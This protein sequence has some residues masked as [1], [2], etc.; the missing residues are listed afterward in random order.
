MADSLPT[1]DTLLSLLNAERVEVVSLIARRL[2]REK[3]LNKTITANLQ[4]ALTRH[5]QQWQAYQ[6]LSD[7][8]STQVPD[9][10]Q[11]LASVAGVVSDLVWIAAVQNTSPEVVI[12]MLNSRQREQVLFQTQVLKAL[13]V[14]E[15][16]DNEVLKAV[17]A[18]EQSELVELYDLAQPVLKTHPL[19]V[20]TLQKLTR[21]ISGLWQ[22][23][24]STTVTLTQLPQLI[25]AGDW[26]TLLK[27]ANDATAEEALRI[28]AIECLA[29][30]D[31]AQ[32]EGALSKLTKE[33]GDED[34]NKAAYRALRR[35]QRA[36]AKLSTGVSA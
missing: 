28:S 6:H 14:A 27:V 20:S 32:I 18:L 25:S 16:V 15:T 23:P 22:A 1:H 7:S 21:R 34:I 19:S 8:G 3:V 5:Y 30:M 26:Q 36:K 2:A 29:V 33:G 11:K 10:A 4:H 12:A 13:L 31:E 17:H 35:R 9:L 24:V